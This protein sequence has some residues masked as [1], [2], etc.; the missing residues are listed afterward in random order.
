MRGGGLRT[1]KE[2]ERCKR[3]EGREGRERE[4]QRRKL[5]STQSFNTRVEG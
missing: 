4:D 2:G 1:I 3:G 5:A